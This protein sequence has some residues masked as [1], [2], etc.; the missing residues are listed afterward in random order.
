[1]RCFRY[2]IVLCAIS[3]S[4]LCPEKTVAYSVVHPAR[5][6]LSQPADRFAVGQPLV[7][8]QTLTLSWQELVDRAAGK[9]SSHAYAKYDGDFTRYWKSVSSQRAGK[10]FEAMVA[11]RDNHPVLWRRLL[12]IARGNKY[13]SIVTAVERANHHP[14]DLV[15]TNKHNLIVQRYQAKLGW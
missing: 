5:S 14:A 2:L 9:P 12:R 15:M 1:M 13:H 11:Y 7:G 3:I 10:T 4:L 6:V 8:P